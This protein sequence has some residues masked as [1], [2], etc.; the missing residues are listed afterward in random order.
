MPIARAGA[1]LLGLVAL[2]AAVRAVTRARPPAPTR[3]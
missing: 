3:T 2:A 1:A